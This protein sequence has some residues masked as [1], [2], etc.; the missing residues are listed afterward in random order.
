MAA[1]PQCGEGDVVVRG[2]AEGVWVGLLTGGM[3]ELEE[4]KREPAVERIQ[5]PVREWPLVSVDEYAV[6]M[7]LH[8]YPATMQ[9][10][11]QHVHSISAI[12][13]VGVQVGMVE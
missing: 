11:F 13:R 3:P 8:C 5:I 4:P 12:E 2:S 6:H 7:L 10:F 9:L 1:G